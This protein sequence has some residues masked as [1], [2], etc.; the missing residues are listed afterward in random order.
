MIYDYLEY[1]TR[2]QY[3]VEVWGNHTFWNVYM[4]TYIIAKNMKY[5]IMKKFN[6]MILF[7]VYVHLKVKYQNGKKI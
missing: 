5:C 1:I 6:N 4:L 2:M 3:L 7:H